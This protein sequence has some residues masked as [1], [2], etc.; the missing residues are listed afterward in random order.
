MSTLALLLVVV[1]GLCL[2]LVFCYSLI[3]LHLTFLY[4][5]CANK[6]KDFPDFPLYLPNTLPFVTVQLPVYNEQYVVERLIDAITALDYPL[7]KLQIQVL[8]DSNDITRD[9]VA[10]KVA[11]YQAQGF[12]ITQVL[13]PERTGYKAGAL[14]YGLN[15]AT[16]EFIAIFDADFLPAPS[17]LKQTLIKFKNPEVGLVQTRW[18]HVN[19]NYSLLTKLQAFGLNAHF[20]VEQT[21]RSCG[22]YFINFN[23]TGG[24]WRKTCILDA[25]GWQTDT[26]TEDLDLSYR[27][28]LRHWEFRYLEPI[29]APAELPVTMPAIKSQQYRWTKGAA[30]NARKNLGPVFQS[31][32]PWSTKIHALFHLGNSS[33]FVCVFL[34]A[35]LSVPILFIP[36]YYPHLQ[37]Y[38][39]SQELFLISLASLIAF[40]WTSFR[41]SSPNQAASWLQFCP[42]FFWFL[43][44]SMGLSLHNTVAVLEGYAGK[45]TPFI[46]TPKF[47]IQ[48]ASDPW[49]NNLYRTASINFLMLLE[50]ILALYFLAGILFG[51]YLQRYGLLPFHSMLTLGFGGVFFLTV[52]HSR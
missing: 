1:Y 11:F 14:E 41:C 35:L 8:D 18:G 51:F 42:R 40:Y 27:A 36:D 49:R 4:Y 38:F 19:S 24:V 16:G 26:L 23:G 47:N 31:N 44:F 6:K 46:R 43:C 29:I 13:R 22:H 12:D 28:Q 2:I 48:K 15:L 7:E 34:L 10:A 5:R 33:V 50:G 39:L 30:E 3:Q 25:G 20:T 9:L 21:G 17:F 32:K 45:K 52:K 37:A